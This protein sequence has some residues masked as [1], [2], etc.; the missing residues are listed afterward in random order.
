MEES[1]GKGI[2]G[3]KDRER[4]RKEASGPGWEGGRG[5]GREEV[6]RTEAD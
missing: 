1:G 5:G 2:R 4:S 6:R 3:R